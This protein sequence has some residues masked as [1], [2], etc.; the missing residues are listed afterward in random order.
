MN[1]WNPLRHHRGP[2][3]LQVMRPR[4]VTK[5]RHR[6]GCTVDTLN[7]T[8]DRDDVRDDAYALL[9]DP[10]DTIESVYV[11]S[12]REQQHVT[13]YRKDDAR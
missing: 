7:G 13:T 1:P 3:R 4:T 8:V 2:F 6:A 10:R 9:D 5:T 12:E 11:W